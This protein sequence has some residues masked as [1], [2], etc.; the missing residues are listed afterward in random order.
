MFKLCAEIILR[1]CGFSCYSVRYC[2]IKKYR[3]VCL[4]KKN[5]PRDES[6]AS[7][8]ETS[9]TIVLLLLLLP[10]RALLRVKKAHS[11]RLFKGHNGPSLR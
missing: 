9:G 4:K 6:L 1:L 11:Y 2:E 7:G 3:I 5:D 10:E 8:K